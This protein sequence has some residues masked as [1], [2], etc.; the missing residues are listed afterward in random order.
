MKR[1]ETDNFLCDLQHGLR[2]SGS[3]DTQISSIRELVSSHSKIIKVDLL[4][5][6][7]AKAFDKVS[8]KR[9]IYKLYYYDISNQIEY[10]L[11]LTIEHKQWY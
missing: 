9:T 6:D 5:M 11:S 4:I 2:Q 8:H 3:R 7:F 10:N 1:L